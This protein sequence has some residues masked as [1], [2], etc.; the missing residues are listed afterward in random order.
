[1]SV[2]TSA[3]ELREISPDKIVQNPENPRLF[4]RDDELNHLQASI[5]KYGIQVPLTVY[6]SGGRTYTLIDGERRWRCARKLNLPRVPAIV[7]PRPTPL[8]NILL[9][10][11]IHAL[12]EQWDYFTIANK[13]PRIIKLYKIDNGAE[14]NENELSSIT[15]LSRGQIRRCR[16]LLDLPE[17]YK[18]DLTFELQKPKQQQRLSEDLFIEMERALKTVQ[19]YVPGAIDN[20]NS[21]RD[22]LIDKYRSDIIKNVTDF[23]KLS[24]MATSVTKLDV[25]ESSVRRSIKLIVNPANSVDIETVYAQHFELR[26]DERRT[27]ISVQSVSDFIKYAIDK[28]IEIDSSLCKE[29]KRLRMLID[30]LLG[31]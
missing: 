11:N 7:Q 14:P 20:L 21:A 8:D 31:D 23:R 16:F 18:R 28:D 25:K 4:F 29:L 22:T 12:R 24:K 17:R 2:K 9:M 10:F 3:G 5:R 26:Y 13:L 27:L 6:H 30:D 19:T 15:G 1:M